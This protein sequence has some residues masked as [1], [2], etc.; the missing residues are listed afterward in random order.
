MMYKTTRTMAA[1]GSTITKGFHDLPHISV[2]LC[3]VADDC[4][5]PDWRGSVSGCQGVFTTTRPL[6]STG[7]RSESG[8]SRRFGDVCDMSALA[9]TTAVM[10][11]CRERQKGARLGHRKK[12]LPLTSRVPAPAR[13]HLCACRIGFTLRPSPPP[14]AIRARDRPSP[15]PGI[16]AWLRL[17][18]RRSSILMDN[19]IC[20]AVS[21]DASDGR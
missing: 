9:P 1:Q 19:L 4:R 11:Q 3:L 17:T 8:Q 7:P 16:Q 14:S 15:R 5:I 21:C 12:E 20:S 18:S 13:H 10:M 6:R 2:A